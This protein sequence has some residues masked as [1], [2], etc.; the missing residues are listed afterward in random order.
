MAEEA[1]SKFHRM[2]EGTVEDWMIIG[3]SHMEFT[4]GTAKRVLRHLELLDGDYGGF[5]VDR[6]KHSLQTA[7]LAMRDGRDEEYVVCALLHDI[8]DTL[9]PTNH[10]SIAAG[11]LKPWVSEQNHWIVEHHGIFQG[12]YFWHFLGG[13][14]NDRDRFLEHPFYDSCAEFCEL[15]DQRAFDPKGETLPLQEF[16]P[17][18]ERVFA[19]GQPAIAAAS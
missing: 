11:L 19:E 4:G 3:H 7:T 18:V 17:M 8:G 5:A 6:L 14:R 16:A 15:Y 1:R 10:P 13:D 9:A 12:Y 2:D